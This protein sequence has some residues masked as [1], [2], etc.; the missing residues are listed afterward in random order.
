MAVTM[1][2]QQLRPFLSS[3][4]PRLTEHERRHPD[5]PESAWPENDACREDLRG[6]QQD[7]HVYALGFARLAGV[8]DAEL[9]VGSP[10]KR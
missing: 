2:N 6:L 1:L 4:R 3:W 7:I 8:E 9:L 10:H 5:G